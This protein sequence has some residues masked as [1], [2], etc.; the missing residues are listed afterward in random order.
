M[1]ACSFWWREDLPQY[2]AFTIVFGAAGMMLVAVLAGYACLPYIE[3]RSDGRA[4]TQ[5]DP[6]AAKY[7]THRTPVA[8]PRSLGR[9]LKAIVCPT[10]LRYARAAF[11]CEA[12]S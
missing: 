2:D 12:A 7:I 11:V 6:P 5:L 1:P 10:D 3:S 9:S 4:A 8:Q